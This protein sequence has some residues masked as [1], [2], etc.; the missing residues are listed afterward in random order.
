M[1]TAAGLASV[2]GSVGQYFW[3]GIAGTTFWVDPHERMIAVLLIQAPGRRE[4]YQQLFRG[5]VHAAFDD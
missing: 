5:L 4:Y 2:P 3:G 1:R